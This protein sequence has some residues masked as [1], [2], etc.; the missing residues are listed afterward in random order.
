MFIGGGIGAGIAFGTSFA[1][2]LRSL[3]S[4]R[5]G[6][7][8][9]PLSPE[10]YD[11]FERFKKGQVH[12]NYYLD[13]E[14]RVQ[15]VIGKAEDSLKEASS[16]AAQKETLYAAPSSRYVRSLFTN[17]KTLVGHLQ[18]VRDL[19]LT[20]TM[21]PYRPEMSM[22]EKMSSA[23]YALRGP[24]DQDRDSSSLVQKINH[25]LDEQK[26]KLEKLLET[27][28]KTAEKEK[29]LVES[30]V[31]TY[32]VSRE[33]Y[34][35][36][37]EGVD[38]LPELKDSVPVWKSNMEHVET[39]VRFETIM[40][41][42]QLPPPHD[43]LNSLWEPMPR[44]I[45]ATVATG[46]KQ[47]FNLTLE[48]F[49]YTMQVHTSMV[50]RVPELLEN[51]VVNQNILTMFSTL[52]QVQS[53]DINSRV[54]QDTK[55][56]VHCYQDKVVKNDLAQVNKVVQ[57][58]YA[59]VL[60]ARKKFIESNSY[61]DAFGLLVRLQDGLDSQKSLQVFFDTIVPYSTA[62]QAYEICFNEIQNISTMGLGGEKPEAFDALLSTVGAR[63]SP[64]RV[65]PD[66]LVD[67][68]QGPQRI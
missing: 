15:D 53:N 16:Y 48:T 47:D 62:M 6:T 5:G 50:D 68:K 11:A 7:S 39:V 60:E 66:I 67:P 63:L 40:Y 41:S 43:L 20:F 37:A 18:E 64:Q 2:S 17:Y 12:Y 31:R 45:D 26:T 34:P 4:T 21:Q 55:K 23:L 8:D 25:R 9:F 19:A 35:A 13:E 52:E 1:L 29:Q 14:K 65:E 33:N 42:R 3:G 61:A 27:A 10:V 46:K 57:E 36:L 32:G 28:D 58:D 44:I 49:L 30:I 38:M 54:Y 51:R 24:G 56:A 22:S 59:Q